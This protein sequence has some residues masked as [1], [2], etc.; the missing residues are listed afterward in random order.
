MIIALRLRKTVSPNLVFNL[1]TMSNPNLS[2]FLFICLMIIS[3]HSISICM[4]DESN[5]ASI[6]HRLMPGTSKNDM[7]QTTLV[8]DRRKT[9]NRI[10]GVLRD[11]DT[12]GEE[13]FNY[14][15][16][17]ALGPKNWGSLKPDWKICADGK[18]QSPINIDAN[19]AQVMPG[20]L[21][22]AYIDAPAVLINGVNNIGV[23][24]KGDAGGIEVNG[25]TYKL[26]QCHWHTPS[27]HTID[28]KR[29]DAELHLVHSNG[30]GQK[31]VVG[32]LQNIGPPDPFIGN[33]TEEIDVLDT[34]EEIDLEKISATN[35]KDG[36]KTN[37]RYFGSFTTPPCTEGVIW[38][39]EAQVRSISQ[40]QINLLKGSHQREFRE[41]AR[42]I[43]LLGERQIWKFDLPGAT[44]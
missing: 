31:A 8:D 43:Q 39:I 41:N 37:Y 44:E 28:G 9:L 18:S 11:T 21:K 35:I 3:S 12:G 17:T 30:M 1:A 27:E 32:I 2:P 7:P 20:D 22:R 4:A 25:S 38:T 42:P 26:V 33:L 36:S 15:E 10:N 24:W 34:N 14:I 6:R 5:E 23:I 40:G 16:A 19:S 29:F 13:E